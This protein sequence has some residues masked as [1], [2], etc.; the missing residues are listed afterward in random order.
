MDKTRAGGEVRQKLQL[1]EALEDL[2]DGHR[3]NVAGM[4][5]LSGQV[6]ALELI[7]LALAVHAQANANFKSAWE[8]ALADVGDALSEIHPENAHAAQKLLGRFS[9]GLDAASDPPARQI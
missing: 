9:A 2:Y 6:Q 3:N 4:N 8:K 7:V 5:H 1:G